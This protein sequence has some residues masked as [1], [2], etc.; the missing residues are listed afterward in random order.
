MV[1]ENEDNCLAGVWATRE[2]AVE[3]LDSCEEGG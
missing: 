3:G 1:R 2:E